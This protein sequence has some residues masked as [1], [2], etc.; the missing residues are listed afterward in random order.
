MAVAWRLR[1]S[2]PPSRIEW[3]DIN[4]QVRSSLINRNR[5]VC[6]VA[7][8]GRREAGRERPRGGSGG[9]TAASVG[10][11][12]TSTI[13]GIAGLHPP[14]EGQGDRIHAVGDPHAR[15]IGNGAPRLNQQRLSWRGLGPERSAHQRGSRGCK[16]RASLSRT[17][18][19]C[20]ATLTCPARPM[21]TVGSAAG[22]PCRRAWRFCSSWR[23]TRSHKGSSCSLR[24][25]N[26]S[27]TASPS[28]CGPNC[29]RSL[30][31]S[32]SSPNNSCS[33]TSDK[34]PIQPCT[35]TAL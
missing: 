19:C 21:A 7:G 22:R 13:R 17:C 6:S 16:E 15:G 12:V 31:L 11:G 27:S 1:S 10:R 18:T 9:Q 34:S 32:D 29:W 26:A 35:R 33:I 5:D 23:F 8:P 28:N 2:R 4:I 3:M 30:T 25:R 14:C 24:R 20:C